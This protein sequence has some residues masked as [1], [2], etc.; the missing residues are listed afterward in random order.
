MTK[1]VQDFSLF[2]CGSVRPIVATELGA[3]KSCALRPPRTLTLLS[4]VLSFSHV[5]ETV[6][7]L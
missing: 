4:S 6:T 5:A 3:A 1:V 7:Y 2:P